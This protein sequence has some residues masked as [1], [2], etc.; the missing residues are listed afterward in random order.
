M[1]HTAGLSYFSRL[2][3][4]EQFEQ[5]AL[6][7]IHAR[8]VE[9]AETV[10]AVSDG[11]DWIPKFVDDHRQDAVRILDV[12]HAMAYV[13]DAGQAAHEHLPCPER[14]TKAEERTKFKQARLAQW[15]SKQRRELKEG[16]ASQVLSELERLHTLTQQAQVVEAM[17][18]IQK[19]LNYLKERRAMLAY[20]T[21]QAQGYPITHTRRW[22]A[23]SGS[24]N[25]PGDRKGRSTCPPDRM[26]TL[27]LISCW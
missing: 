4:A 7:E 17:Q 23:V 25:D 8:G 20:A 11:A 27:L 12:A 16:D 10:C 5:A 3:E 15:T 21:F 2:S 22:S 14:L 18:T 24:V 26:A 9:Q 13:A 6:V 19:S 1:V